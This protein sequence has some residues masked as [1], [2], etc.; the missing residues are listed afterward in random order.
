MSVEETKV[1]LLR[2][3][4]IFSPLRE[5]ELDI[6][7]RYSEFVSVPREATCS[8]RGPRPTGFSWSPRAASAS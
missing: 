5:Y 2:K 4:D 6:I 1:E 3:V 8:A 7:A